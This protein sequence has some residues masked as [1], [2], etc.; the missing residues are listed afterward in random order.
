[1]VN[2]SEIHSSSSDSLSSPERRSISPTRSAMSRSCL[3]ISPTMTTRVASEY[4]L[5]TDGE[6]NGYSPLCMIKNPQ[7]PATTPPQ[8]APTPTIQYQSDSTRSGRD[9]RAPSPSARSA[10]APPPARAPIAPYAAGG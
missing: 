1:L 5:A 7:P 10:A 4:W 9:D 3:L 2:P 6:G 8:T